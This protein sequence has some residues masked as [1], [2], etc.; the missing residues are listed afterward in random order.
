MEVIVKVFED[1]ALNKY[2]RGS[3]VVRIT[4]QRG[5]EYEARLQFVAAKL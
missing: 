1:L 4:K 5:A 3:S 2:K